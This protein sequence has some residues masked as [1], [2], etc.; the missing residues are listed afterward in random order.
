MGSSFGVISQTGNNIQTEGLVFYVDAAYK[1]SYPGTGTNAFNLAS[2]S[3]TPTGSLIN[4]TGFVGLL[5]SSFTFDGT[6]DYIECSNDSAT[7]PQTN[8]SINAWVKL[9]SIGRQHS[10]LEKYD[11]TGSQGSYAFRINSGNKFQFYVIIGT[12]GALVESS[13]TL[14]AGIWYNLCS[15][16]NFSTNTGIVYINGIQDNQSTS[17]NIGPATSNNPLKIGARG[18]D[19]NAK[20][21]GNLACAHIYNRALSAADVLQ[22]YQAQKGRF[23]L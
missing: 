17:M 12:S 11:N 23:G 20:L 15:T 2:G 16:Q 8:Y 19:N 21:Q 10:L 3:L 1:K 5:T 4:D 18:N 13:S 14:S 22:N 9:S 7:D 6:D